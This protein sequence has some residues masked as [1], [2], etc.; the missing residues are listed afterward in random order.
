MCQWKVYP[1]FRYRNLCPN[2]ELEMQGTEKR[3]NRG[4]WESGNMGCQLPSSILT[5]AG[6]PFCLVMNNP[7]YGEAYNTW[8]CLRSG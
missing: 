4:V 1:R 7:N 6:L 2:S 5:M 8:T 3:E